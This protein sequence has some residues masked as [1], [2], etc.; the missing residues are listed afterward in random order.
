MIV[1]NSEILTSPGLKTSNNN[2]DLKLRNIILT[3]PFLIRYS[4]CAS[5]PTY[6]SQHVGAVVVVLFHRPAGELASPVPLGFPWGKDVLCRG[7]YVHK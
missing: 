6:T 4:S 2:A 7:S 5:T 3:H 1:P